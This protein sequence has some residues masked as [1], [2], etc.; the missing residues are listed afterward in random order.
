LNQRLPAADDSST[1]AAQY[2]VSSSTMLSRVTVST[3]RISDA[4]AITALR[5]AVA[6]DMTERF[7]KGHWSSCPTESSALRELRTSHVLVARRGKKIIGTVRMAT[8]KPWAIDSSYFA[9]VPKAIY[10]H[11]LAVASDSRG[12]GVARRLMVAIEKA[13]RSWPADSLRLDAYDHEAGAAPFYLKCGFR[14]VGRRTY[15]KVPLI[16]L[17]KLL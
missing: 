16:Y 5:T 11:G 15:R 1:T 13:A 9:D 6:R 10:I 8:Q 2:S 3:A 17:E 4:R 12:S 7:G 14:E